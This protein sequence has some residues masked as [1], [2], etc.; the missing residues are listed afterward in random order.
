MS[1]SYSR[2]DL[3]CKVYVGNLGES[4]G[5]REL[6]NAFVKFGPL[7]NV[8]VARNPPGFAFVEYED[9]RDAEDAVKGLDGHMLCG[10]RAVVEMSTGEKR[11]SRRGG[12]SGPRSASY[13]DKCYTCGERGHFARDCRNSGRYGGYGGGRYSNSDRRRSRRS[14][15]SHSPLTW[16]LIDM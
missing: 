13:D 10:H 7:K 12:R 4:A 6:E 11:T 3:A 2:A 14:R 1:R 15:M 8:W 5:R 16:H 9:S